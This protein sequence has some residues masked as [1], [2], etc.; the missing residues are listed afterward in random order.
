MGLAPEEL[1]RTNP[2]LVLV[3][4][5][6]WGQQGVYASR[7]GFGTLIEGASGFAAMNG[8]ADREPVLPPIYLADGV[9]GLYGAYAV[10]LALR[11]VELNGGKGQVVDLSLLDP[12]IAIL[13]PQAANYRLTGKVKPRTGS[14]STNSA[15]RNA[16]K[17]SDGKYVALSG[18]T[19]RMAERIFEAIGRPDLVHDPKFRSNSDRVRNVDVLDSIIGSFVTRR[20]QAENVAFFEK[21]NVTV[22]PIYDTSQVLEDPHVIARDVLS[23]YPDVDLGWLPMPHVAP[24]LCGIPG[25]IRSPAPRLGANNRS[26][27]AE[28]NVDDEHYERLVR[29]HVV[30]CEC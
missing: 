20:T 11:E 5:S 13:G 30:H 28:I 8:F 16:Y 9:A 26:I 17:C 29:D 10:L 4:I 7:P 21:A 2:N 24:R 19:Q 6:G 3:R 15:P 14:R 12:L 1:L 18:S 25:A 27:L 22:G 23:D